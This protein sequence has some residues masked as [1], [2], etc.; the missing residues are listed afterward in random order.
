MR[1]KAVQ[2]LSKVGKRWSSHALK[3]KG[4]SW[5]ISHDGHVLLMDTVSFV[6][7]FNG[8]MIVATL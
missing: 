7:K 6:M 4:Q 8:G 1:T 3:K 5:K 2:K